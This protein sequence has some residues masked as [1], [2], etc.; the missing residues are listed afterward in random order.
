[1][2][3]APMTDQLAFWNG[4]A[5]RNWTDF[6]ETLDA[7][8]VPVLQKL[9]ARGAIKPGERVIDVGC[10]CGASS[11]ELGNQVGAH[12][13]VLGIDISSDML[14]R[15]RHRTPPGLHVRY[16]LADAASHA[17]VPDHFDVL[18]SRFGV[19]FFDDPERAFT[20]LAGAM[21][22]G[23][24]VVFACWRQPR[25][26]PYFILPLQE[27]YKHVPK[28]PEVKPNDPGPF[29]FASEDRVHSILGAA[30]FTSIGMEPFDTP[31]DMAA[32]RG[33]DHAMHFALSIGP[34]ARALEGQPQ[35][36][37][38]AAAQSIR[39]A[40]AQ[41]ASGDSVNLKGAIWIV[42]AVRP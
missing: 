19:M 38:T 12:G 17:F 42:T 20:N 2:T 9:L 15:A 22:P 14:T 41:H 23:G 35:D 39:D 33:L 8:F 36:K 6:Q 3:S 21:R 11:I 16:Q 27:A 10:G 28:L 32:G 24:R 34:A 40:L 18:F 5:G 13:E 25:D 1:M 29:A 30:G 7:T 26:N 37:I 31:L 4:S